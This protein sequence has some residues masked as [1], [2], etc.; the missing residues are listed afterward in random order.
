[1]NEVCN[2]AE[3][4]LYY[5]YKHNIKNCTNKKL[6]KLLYYIQ[7]WSLALNGKAIF[8]D[9]F[10][11]WLHGPVI[12]SIYQKYKQY[13]FNPLPEVKKF[14]IKKLEKK[15]IEFI[16]AVL[17]KYAGFDAEFLE[18]RTHIEDPWKIARSKS[19]ISSII[20][21]KSMRDY[22]RSVKK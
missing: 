9:D 15:D 8:S 17:D 20:T 4:V 3:Y 11:A 2:I 10:E 19:T 7:A 14:D 22:Y 12:P 21:K 16:D 5:C 18:Y 1:M 6:Q 13:S